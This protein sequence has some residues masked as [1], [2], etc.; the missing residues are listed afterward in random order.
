MLTE[1][2]SLVDELEM[3]AQDRRQLKLEEPCRFSLKI[4]LIFFFKF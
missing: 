4:V 2:D 3:S 1:G